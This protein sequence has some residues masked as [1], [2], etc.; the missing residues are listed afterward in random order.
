MSGHDATE[1]VIGCAYADTHHASTSR[2]KDCETF[3]TLPLMSKSTIRTRYEGGWR[4][5]RELHLRSCD[6]IAVEQKF[7]MN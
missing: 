1:V 7:D 3:R 4:R 6:R 5:R 2:K